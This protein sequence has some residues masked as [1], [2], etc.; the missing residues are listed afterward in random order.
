MEVKFLTSKTTSPGV[1]HRVGNRLVSSRPTI[2]VMIISV[3]NSLAAQVPIYCPSRMMVTSSEILR[4]SSILW[5]MYTMETPF[6]RSSSTMVKS[7]STSAAVREEVG[8]SR[9]RTLQSAETAL[10]ISTSC[11][12]DTDRVFSLARGS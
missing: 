6:A 9:I 4:I 10:A 11:I 3:V 12:C 5:E 1:L 2:L 8:S 7:A